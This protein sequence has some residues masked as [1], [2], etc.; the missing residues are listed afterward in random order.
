MQLT[1]QQVKRAAEDFKSLCV[2]TYQQSGFTQEQL[3][4]ECHTN[5]ANISRW[6]SYATD[7]HLPAFLI[8]LMPQSIAQPVVRY[9][10]E[11]TG[12]HLMPDLHPTDKLDGSIDDEMTAMIEKMGALVDDYK[13]HPHAINRMKKRILEMLEVVEKMEAE[14]DHKWDHN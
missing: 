6:F 9:L 14:V 12:M 5:Q 3:A 13:H 8:L 7:T 2:D 4:D 11:H 10:A 1:N